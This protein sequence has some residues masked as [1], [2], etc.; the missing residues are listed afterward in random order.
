MATVPRLLPPA[1]ALGAASVLVAVV[2][3]VGLLAAWWGGPE[4]G[5]AASLGGLSVL[6]V[7]LRAED[8]RLPLGF[9]AVVAVLAALATTAAGDP[10]LLAMIVA[11]SAVAG[12]PL[13]RRL[14]PVIG[15]APVVVAAAGTGTASLGA[16]EAAVGVMAGAASVVLVARLTLSRRL[17]PEPLSRRVTWA[18]MG[19]LAIG[20]GLAIGIATL[21]ELPNALWVVVALCAV[22][23]PGYVETRARAIGRVTGTLI[24]ALV[25]AVIA[26]MLPAWVLVV[27]AG[28]ALLAGISWA[29]VRS[30]RAAGAYVAVATVLIAG[31]GDLGAAWDTALDRVGLTLLGAA[32]AMV[33][34]LGVRAVERRE[35]RA[36]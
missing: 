5:V 9:G 15:S 28:L 19:T 20:S 21:L 24:G 14:G 4:L 32:I 31:A 12:Q 29:L 36:A 2:L 26:T 25:G 30:R 33:L 23:V 34:A 8:P 7:T 13:L 22:L 3:G 1:K 35:E 17:P 10:L 6:L 27:L 11:A 16:G 18:F